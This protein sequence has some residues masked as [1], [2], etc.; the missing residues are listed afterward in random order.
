MINL[1]FPPVVGY[2]GLSQLL[3]RSV[4]T[5]QADRCRNPASVP[6]ACTPPGSRNP[7]WVVSDV[8]EWLQ[9][10][11]QPVALPPSDPPP[12]RRGRPT[13]AEQ[14]ESARKGIWVLAPSLLRPVNRSWA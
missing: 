14:L 10:H 11:R 2:E 4:A 7:L 12:R 13:K 1:N 9:Q 6:P 8:I 3:Q 5:L